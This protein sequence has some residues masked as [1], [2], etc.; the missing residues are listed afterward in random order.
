M[1]KFSTIQRFQVGASPATCKMG[2]ADYPFDSRAYGSAL[3]AEGYPL[4]T[5]WIEGDWDAECEA[6][7]LGLLKTAIA[8]GSFPM[9]AVACLALVDSPKKAQLTAQLSTAERAK[10]VSLIKIGSALDDECG[11][12]IRSWND[13]RETAQTGRSKSQLLTR[14]G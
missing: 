10:L 13:E 8:H 1:S 4:I 7:C 5:R 11:T 6:E 14:A 9:L 3:R 12:I 2:G